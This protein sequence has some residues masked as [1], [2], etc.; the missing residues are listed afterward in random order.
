[1]TSE[2][3]TASP[4]LA[5]CSAKAVSKISSV[6]NIV[7]SVTAMGMISVPERVLQVYNVDVVVVY[8]LGTLV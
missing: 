6:G 2:R 7:G 4:S 3:S 5:S 1:M 8:E